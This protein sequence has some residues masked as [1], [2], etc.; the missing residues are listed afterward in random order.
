MSLTNAC[1]GSHDMEYRSETILLSQVCESTRS[2][3]L[4]R[5]GAEEDRLHFGW[6]LSWQ[7]LIF[8]KVTSLKLPLFHVE[9]SCL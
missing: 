1:P 7:D 9:G 4:Y 8:V 6:F 2:S 3:T 5:G